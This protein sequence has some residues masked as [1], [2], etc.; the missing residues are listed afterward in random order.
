MSQVQLPCVESMT[1][2]NRFWLLTTQLG[3]IESLFSTVKEIAEN[4]M[5]DSPQV[6]TN[7]VGS[8]CPREAMNP[9]DGRS[10]FWKGF[11]QLPGG[12]GLAGIPIMANR[13]L[14]G[15]CERPRQGQVDLTR[16][17]RGLAVTESQIF[18]RDF[19]IMKLSGEF[20]VGRIGSG[21]HHDPRSFTVE[22]MNDAG[23]IF[24]SD[25]GDAIG[26]TEQGIHQSAFRGSP[27]DG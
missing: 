2:E 24:F 18:L 23:S 1:F 9:T 11:A 20:P 8:S 15:V 27:G 14:L 13:P 4:R 6:D 3:Q 26:M 12:K 7:L 21:N 16:S 22:P 5:S 19:A 25:L 17:F 10:Q